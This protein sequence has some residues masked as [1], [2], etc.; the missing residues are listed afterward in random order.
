MKA[1]IGL[2]NPGEEYKGTR[3]NLGRELAQ[4]LIRRWGRILPRRR[5][6][7]LLFTYSLQGEEIGIVMPRHFVNLSGVSIKAF[8]DLTGISLQDMLI[9]CDD[10]NLPLGKIRIRPRGSNGGH[11]GLRSIIESLGTEDFPRLRMGVGRPPDE[12]DLVEFVLSPFSSDEWPV[13][14]EMLERAG[15]AV[16][17]WIRSGMEKAMSIYNC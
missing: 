4:R 9:A 15:D 5:R 1:I 3:H 8:R 7:Y 10:V 12:G 11:K 17:E 13:V 2:G 16:E 14:E 6:E